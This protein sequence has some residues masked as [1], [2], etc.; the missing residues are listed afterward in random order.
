MQVYQE[1][2]LASSGV[3]L[4][5]V[6]GYFLVEKETSNIQFNIHAYQPATRWHNVSRVTDWTNLVIQRFLLNGDLVDYETYANPADIDVFAYRLQK[7]L[8]K[9]YKYALFLDGVR[10]SGY[11]LIPDNNNNVIQDFIEIDSAFADD[12]TIY[13]EFPIV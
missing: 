9:G 13:F 3:S 7:P 2:N 11:T 6:D 10:M 5:E 8:H 12:K 1:I 4:E